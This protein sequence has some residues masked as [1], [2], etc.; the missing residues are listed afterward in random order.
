LFERVI[1]TK[2]GS[3]RLAAK[4]AKT[5]FNKIIYFYGI[6][7]YMKMIEDKQLVLHK[8]IYKPIA[9]VP[10]AIF[11]ITGMTIGA[12][13]LGIPYVV[14]QVGLKIGL[15]YIVIL[16]TVILAL[17]LMLGDIAVR[18]K[19]ELQIPGLAGKYL[20]KW[21]RYVLSATIIFSSAGALLAYMIGEGQSLA[22]VFGGSQMMWGVVFWSLASYVIWR[23]FRSVK[24]F[25]KILSLAVM[26]LIVGLS[27]FLLPKFQTANWNN[28][29]LSGILLPF[30]VILFALHSAPAIVEA[31]ALLPGSQKHFRRALITGTVIPIVLYILF[32]LAVTGA[33]GLGT[34]EVATVG[35]GLVYG[36]A[37]F[38]FGNLLAILAMGTGFVGVG[39]ALKHSLMWDNKIDKLPAEL[40]VIAAPLL[41][42]LLGIRS[43]VS[44]LGL[45]GGV[46]IGLEAVLL[47]LTCYQARRKG[48]LEASRYGLHH[49][50]I[51]AAPVLLVFVIFTV[52]SLFHIFE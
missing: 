47:I 29:D 2:S 40:L 7:S 35:L 30:G 21:A 13:V 48:D 17:N 49:F 37:F 31:H 27:V 23:G 16:G 32:A 3:P 22:A 24:K 20:G 10:E 26:F 19:E 38:I 4:K 50:W 11:M 18:T 28:F 44:V 8:G 41:F 1:P 6:I 12:G 39:S 42:Y 46:F 52:L 51:L 43:F 14:A 25:E 9:T 34:T 5:L 36:K 45:V 33:T 15:L